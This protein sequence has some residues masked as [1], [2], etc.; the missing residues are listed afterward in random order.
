MFYRISIAEVLHAHRVGQRQIYFVAFDVGAEY[1]ERAADHVDSS[2]A[3]HQQYVRLRTFK[4]AL[5]VYVHVE[6]IAQIYGFKAAADDGLKGF[7][8]VFN[9]AHFGGFARL[10]DYNSDFIHILPPAGFRRMEYTR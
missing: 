4:L 9:L 7:E 8:S 6:R 3:H 5:V 1:D 10:F 2:V